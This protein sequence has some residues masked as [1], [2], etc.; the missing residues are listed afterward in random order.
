MIT[1]DTIEAIEDYDGEAAY[2]Y[3][4]DPEARAW[5]WHWVSREWLEEHRP[6][7]LASLEPER[8]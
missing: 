3:G 7:I 4:F 1:L 8:E 6:D 5:S 2:C